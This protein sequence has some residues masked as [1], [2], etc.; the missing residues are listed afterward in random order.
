MFKEYPLK[1]KLPFEDGVFIAY[2]RNI[3]LR[4]VAFCEIN[5]A[6]DL[7]KC[8]QLTNKFIQKALN[9]AFGI[10]TGQ[11]RT[12]DVLKNIDSED[13]EEKAFYFLYI[14]YRE[15]FRKSNPISNKLLAKVRLYEFKGPEKN[16]FFDFDCKLAWDYLLSYFSQE[17]FTTNL[18]AIMW[19]RYRKTLIKCKANE[20]EDFVYN[21]YLKDLKNKMV[22]TRK[23]PEKNLYLAIFKRAERNYFEKEIFD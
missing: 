15:L 7:V 4:N 13:D 17:K 9:A 2:Y 8:T 22:L 16:V 11:I 10:H 5:S 19:F 18:F 12:D 21:L 20:Y 1:N 14:V 23:K 3:L 6:K